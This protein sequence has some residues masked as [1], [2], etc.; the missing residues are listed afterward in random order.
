MWIK[1]SIAALAIVGALGVATPA[2]TL[3]QGVYFGPNGV[4]I[5]TGRRPDYRGNRGF[6]DERGYGG[7]CR[8]ITIRRDDG[9]M[10]QIRRCD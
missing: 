8:T 2:P 7:D 1:T 10:K 4:G 9:S 5:D 3:A 6:A